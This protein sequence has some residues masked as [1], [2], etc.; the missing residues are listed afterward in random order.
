[1][2]GDIAAHLSK[3][4]LGGHHRPIGVMLGAVD[5]ADIHLLVCLFIVLRVTQRPAQ[6]IVQILL[7]G[8]LI[9]VF[10]IVDDIL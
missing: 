9:R 7:V 1:M 6:I 2:I 8:G 4:P 10:R 3:L 5:G